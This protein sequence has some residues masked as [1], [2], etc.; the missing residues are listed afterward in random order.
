M[1]YIYIH[2]IYYIYIYIHYVYIYIYIAY[3]YI[4]YIYNVNIYIYIIYIHYIYIYIYHSYIYIT[5]CAFPWT[6]KSHITRLWSR[7][8]HFW[9]WG[10]LKEPVRLAVPHSGQP[11]SDQ[12]DMVVNLVVTLL[13]TDV[14]D[15]LGRQTRYFIFMCIYIYIIYIYIYLFTCIY[16]WFEFE[17]DSSM[18]PRSGSL[19]MYR[20]SYACCLLTGMHVSLLCAS[21]G[22]GMNSVL[23]SK[24]G[25]CP[26]RCEIV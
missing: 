22:W 7:T 25:I 1:T 19:Y 26:G 15:F 24:G 14:L 21:W 3:I 13:P 23:C 8:S 5:L 2:Y 4:M 6:W 12:S 20:F 18:P 9:D 17:F 11:S 16:T 10:H